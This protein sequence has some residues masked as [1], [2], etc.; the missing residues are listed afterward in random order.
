MWVTRAPSDADAEATGRPGERVP[1]RRWKKT[2]ILDPAAQ[3][4][5]VDR[6]G[7]AFAP[8]VCAL[9][10]VY[11][12]DSERRRGTRR[13]RTMSRWRLGPEP[14]HGTRCTCGAVPAPARHCAGVRTTWGPGSGSA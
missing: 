7:R 8:E 14:A 5:A 13:P 9:D 2:T 3:V 11:V 12:R 1:R 6:L 4:A 10:R